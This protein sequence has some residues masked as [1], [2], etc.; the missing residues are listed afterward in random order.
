MSVRQLTETTGHIAADASAYRLAMRKI[1]AA[2]AVVAAVHDGRRAGLTVTAVCSVSAD[3]P[4]ILCCV[5]KTGRAHVCIAE[6]GRFGVSFLTSDQ[7]DVARR[8]AQSLADADDKFAVGQWCMRTEVAPVLVDALV[9]F[10]CELVQTVDCGTHTIYVGRIL[11]IDGRDER[12]LV[13][14]SGSFLDL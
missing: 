12:S 1:P 6:A 5:N 9:S 13:Y 11:S 3:P 7:G 10:D 14:K 8:F 4:Q 2:V